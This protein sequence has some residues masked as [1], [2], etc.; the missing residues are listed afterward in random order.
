MHADVLLIYLPLEPRHCQGAKAAQIA[1]ISSLM[2]AIQAEEEDWTPAPTPRAG[3]PSAG[4]PSDAQR[5]G[6][7][8]AGAPPDAQ[9]TAAPPRD[10]LRSD[11][12]SGVRPR[13]SAEEDAALRQAVAAVV[14]SG[15]PAP[16]GRE[17]KARIR[18]LQAEANDAAQAS[19]AAGADARRA[20]QKGDLSEAGRLA[21][22]AESFASEARAKRRMAEQ[23]HEAAGF[24]AGAATA[25]PNARQGAKPQESSDGPH[26][27]HEAQ[28]TPLR[29]SGFQV[30]LPPHNSSSKSVRV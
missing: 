30:V 29:K 13:M 18:T 6:A 28:G 22:K 24:G 2:G 10:A 9:S 21:A 19:V 14:G 8:S 3:A 1:S 5:A 4:A 15:A 17:A 16:A 23:I 20:L 7:P 26:E 11:G 27:A 12:S 25:E